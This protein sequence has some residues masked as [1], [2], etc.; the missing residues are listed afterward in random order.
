MS[1]KELIEF[2]NGQIVYQERICEMN[3]GRKDPKSVNSQA[4]RREKIIPSYQKVIEAL[5]A[6]N[7]CLNNPMS[8]DNKEHEDFLSSL[9][10]MSDL[11]PE[12][13]KELNISESDK[14]SM[15]ICKVLEMAGEPLGIDQ[16]LIGLYRLKNRAENRAALSRKLYRM[17]KDEEIISVPKRKGI[18]A[19]PDYTEDSASEGEK[20]EAPE[21][22]LESM[23]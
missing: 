9:S 12:I 18:Y 15:D 22:A 10:D 1:V 6:Y 3:E 14:L 5:E 20:E 13:R 8:V 11:P 16:I 4:L 7:Q 17:T 23:L 21:G 19:L 2:V